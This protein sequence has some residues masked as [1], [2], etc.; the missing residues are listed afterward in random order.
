MIEYTHCVALEEEIKRV[1]KKLKRQKY[2][3]TQAC[4]MKSTKHAK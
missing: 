3:G 4:C 1:Q 2:M